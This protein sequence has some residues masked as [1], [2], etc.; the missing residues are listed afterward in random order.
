MFR[1]LDSEPCAQADPCDVC[2]TLKEVGP[3][4]MAYAAAG[5]EVVNPKEST[6]C[7]HD[8]PTIAWSQQVTVDRAKG[9]HLANLGVC[10]VS[11]PIALGVR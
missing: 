9:W 2:K 1:L 3:P 8:K 7:G 5:F 11:R 10:P 6:A 4:P